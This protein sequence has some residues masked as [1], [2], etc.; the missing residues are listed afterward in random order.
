MVYNFGSNKLYDATPRVLDLAAE[1]Y[2]QL[3]NY[4]S[5]PTCSWGMLNFQINLLWLYLQ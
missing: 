3:K 5:N 1:T 4:S 2:K